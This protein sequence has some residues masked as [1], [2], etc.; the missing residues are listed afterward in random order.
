MATS[1]IETLCPSRNQASIEPP[2][3]PPGLDTRNLF[4]GNRTVAINHHGERYI[5]RLT[6]NGRL[7]LTK[8]V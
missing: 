6:R 2:I 1:K 7:I 5:L 3:L 8:E 4:H